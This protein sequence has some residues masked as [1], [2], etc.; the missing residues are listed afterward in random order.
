M[1]IKKGINTNRKSVDYNRRAQLESSSDEIHRFKGSHTMCRMY[2]DYFINGSDA[3]L[4]VIVREGPSDYNYVWR[5]IGNAS[6]IH[7]IW[8]KRVAVDIGE[9]RTPFSVVIEGDLKTQ[10][11]VIAID[12]ITFDSCGAIKTT[13]GVCRNDE[14]KCP[15]DSV[16]IN[17]SVLYSFDLILK[18]IYS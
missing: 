1:I 10:T 13:S 7:P 11:Q 18:L 5:A 17:Q 12:E 4:R 8:Q 15:M 14:F 16:C 6:Q 3:T 2:F 9:H